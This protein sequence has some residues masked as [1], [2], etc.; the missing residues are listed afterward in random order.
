MRRLVV[1]MFFVVVVVAG[2]AWPVAADSLDQRSD[3]TPTDDG[4]DVR[5]LELGRPGV[6][7]RSSGGTVSCSYV[8]V[9]EAL[10]PSGYGGHDGLLAGFAVAGELVE[11]W[12]YFAACSV[13]GQ[14][15]SPRLFRYVPGDLP[16]DARVLAAEAVDTLVVAYPEPHASPPLDFQQLVGLRTWLWITPAGFE[17]VTATASI[18]GLAVTAT[19]TPSGVVWDLGDGAEPVTCAGPGV[20][21]DPTRA[22]TAPSDC[23]HVYQ[24]AGSYAAEVTVG[25]TI[26]WSASNG[27]GGTLP[28]VERTT[29][30]PVE[31]I[32]RQAV[33][34]DNP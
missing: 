16:I 32:E 9:G 26:E 33:V 17:P 15:Q 3:V 29:T 21:H 13:D 22:E 14:P 24:D 10:D 25:W 30:F 1:A 12:W 18:P 20:P 5:A 6:P 28:G 27:D 7:T 4:A 2:I 11:G 8:E 34:V 23:S 31:V 19:A